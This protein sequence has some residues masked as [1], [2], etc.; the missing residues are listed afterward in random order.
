M[1]TT[2]PNTW[3]P[4]RFVESKDYEFVWKTSKG[5]KLICFPAWDTSI[6]EVTYIPLNPND[7]LM[8]ETIRKWKDFE[9]IFLIPEVNSTS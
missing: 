6:I 7:S 4:R 1:P 2:P 5:Q 8:H 3:K 9:Y